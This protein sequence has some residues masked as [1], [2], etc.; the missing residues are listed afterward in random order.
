MTKT[1]NMAKRSFHWGASQCSYSL[2]LSQ[3][4]NKTDPV[5]EHPCTKHFCDKNRDDDVG[6]TPSVLWTICSYI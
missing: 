1:D 2:L 3:K 5:N 4:R 6:V